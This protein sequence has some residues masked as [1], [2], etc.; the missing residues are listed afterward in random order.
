MGYARPVGGGITAAQAA[1]LQLLST[2]TSSAT[3]NSIAER[4]GTGAA[5]FSNIYNEAQIDAILS[6]YLQTSGNISSTE[7]VN[8][9]ITNALNGKLD[10]DG[11]IAS[12]SGT[13][14]TIDTALSSK[15]DAGGSSQQI[16]MSL[17]GGAVTWVDNSLMSGFSGNV[18]GNGAFLTNL[19]VNNPFN[20]QLNTNNSVEFTGV[21][22][23][24]GSGT[25][26]LGY[27]G[28]YLGINGPITVPSIRD[29][30]TYSAID[31]DDK[32]LLN[33]SDQVVIDWTST[34]N[35]SAYLSFH[36]GALVIANEIYDTSLYA[37]IWPNSRTLTS[38]SATL[39]DWSGTFN[40]S[41]ALSWDVLKNMYVSTAIIYTTISQPTSPTE[42]LTYYDS[43]LHKLRVWNGSAWLNIGGIFTGN[44]F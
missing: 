28:G 18:Y 21:T 43:A 32:T 40:G 17:G 3:P 27:N 29:S 8:S 4:D 26:A 42:G 23:D 41:S 13:N 22:I 37:T 6:G 19:P 10:T 5:N 34:Y 39:V 2:A 20:Q 30:F 1:L 16:L 12:T 7:G 11:S 24:G 15:V 25:T 14:T 38:Q 31:I 9:D 33:I 36:G 44:M 35:A